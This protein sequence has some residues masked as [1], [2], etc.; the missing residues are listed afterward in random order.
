M[1]QGNTVHTENAGE[2]KPLFPV[3]LSI[4]P[5][6]H[7]QGEVA[8]PELRAGSWPWIQQQLQ[9]TSVQTESLN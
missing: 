4:H 1:L 5:T 9:H 7:G 2:A 6:S 8:A 3:S